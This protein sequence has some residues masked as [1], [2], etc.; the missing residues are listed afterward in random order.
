MR[1]GQIEFDE[2]A[3]VMVE[4]FYRTPSVDELRTAFRQFDQDNSGYIQAGEMEAVFKKLGRNLSRA[5][6]EEVV[7]AL[8]TSG[9]G[10][11][12][13]DEFARIFND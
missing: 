4:Q 13:F 2:F 11:I 3:R 9:D 1:K 8:D 12:S 6:V 10:K 5:E 7:R